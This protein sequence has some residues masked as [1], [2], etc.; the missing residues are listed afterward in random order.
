[1][2]QASEKSSVQ[3][4]TSINVSRFLSGIEFPVQKQQLLQK[5]QQNKADQEVITMIQKLDDRQYTDMADVMKGFGT[6][7]YGQMGQEQKIQDFGQQGQG[8][9]GQGLGQQGQGQSRVQP[10]QTQQK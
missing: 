8:L 9:K 2:A 5:A 6:Q 1:M 10:K 7:Q 4:Q 3:G